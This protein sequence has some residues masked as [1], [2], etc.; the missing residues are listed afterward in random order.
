MKIIPTI[1]LDFVQ[2]SNMFWSTS[3]FFFFDTQTLR[4]HEYAALKMHIYNL[5]NTLR[6]WQ[7]KFIIKIFKRFSKCIIA[8]PRF[9]VCI[10]SLKNDE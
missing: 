1:I 10:L 6:D 3:F 4:L 2:S 7:E 5:T 8:W 9:F